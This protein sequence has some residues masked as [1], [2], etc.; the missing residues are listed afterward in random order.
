VE[1]PQL[2][3]KQTEK[4]H[5]LRLYNSLQ[6]EEIKRH[7]WIE[8]EKAGRDL[9]QD[10]VIDWI[11]RYAESF[12]RAQRSAS[13]RKRGRGATDDLKGRLSAFFR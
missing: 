2:W 8:S 7:K 10:A 13:E 11:E 1:L 6:L 3:W 9:G 4:K 5:D 12:R